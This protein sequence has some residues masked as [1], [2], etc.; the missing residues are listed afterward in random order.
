M[1]SAN[2]HHTNSDIDPDILQS[3]NDVLRAKDIYPPYENQ[4]QEETG[5]N[6]EKSQQNHFPLPDFEQNSAE[7]AEPHDQPETEKNAVP[8]FNLGMQMLENGRR[9]ASLMRKAPPSQSISDQKAQKP[10]ENV[11]KPEI[12]EPQ[13]QPEQKLPETT[14]K[15]IENEPEVSINEQNDEII[16]QIM[17]EPETAEA[18]IIEETVWEEVENYNISTH[19]SNITKTRLNRTEESVIAEIVAKDIE[20]FLK[21][22]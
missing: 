18:D 7:Q 10:V 17:V 6:L 3:R 1:N 12:V 11:Q 5:E 16:E 22:A 21:S 9:N 4:P 15:P 13:P 14:Q 20:Q 8:R 19:V 2:T